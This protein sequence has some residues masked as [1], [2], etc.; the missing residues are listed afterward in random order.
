MEGLITTDASLSVLAS[1][2]GAAVGSDMGQGLANGLDSKIAAV[3]AAARRL[4]NAATGSMKVTAEIK[5][6]SKKMEREI[7][8][9]MAQ[10]VVV[11]L[12]QGLKNMMGKIKA[13]TNGIVG[14][15]TSGTANVASQAKA[16]SQSMLREALVGK[17]GASVVQNNTFTTQTLSPYEQRVQLYKMDKDLAEVFA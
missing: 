17:Q 10:G 14:G 15:L 8:V 4:A 6:P 16:S 9:P 3:K 7:G 13:S 12:E 11:G 5:S 2:N 1:Q